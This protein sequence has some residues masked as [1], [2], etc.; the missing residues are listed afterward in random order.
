MLS[1]L[2]MLALLLVS[3][4]LG[5]AAAVKNLDSTWA[6][7]KTYSKSESLPPLEIPPELRE[8]PQKLNPNP[9]G[10]KPVSPAS[11]PLTSERDEESPIL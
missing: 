11:E 8:N 5:C 6:T 7:D 2:K 3:L 9:Q 4:L 1:Q 10:R